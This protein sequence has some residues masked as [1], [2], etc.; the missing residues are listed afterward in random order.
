MNWREICR[1]IDLTVT[2]EQASAMDMLEQRGFGFCKEFGTDNAIEL[3]T[4]MDAAIT[5]NYLYEWL[6]IRM[7]MSC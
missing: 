1:S 3:L 7:G 5:G 4:A 2:A 6:R